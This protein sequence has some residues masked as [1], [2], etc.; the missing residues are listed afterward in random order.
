MKEIPQSVSESTRKRNPALY[1]TH[2][3]VPIAEAKPMERRLRQSSKPK[4]N[5]LENDFY[6]TIKS[7]RP[8]F[9]PIRI[10]AKRYLLGN[11]I[12]YKPDFTCSDY[13]KYIG[14]S[15]PSKETAWEVKGPH[16]FR[17]GYENLKV[18]ASTYPEIRF[19]LVWRDKQTGGWTQQEIL[20]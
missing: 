14:E 12:W 5:K 9:P 1:P 8:N 6:E 11:G 19:I 3:A 2:G 20:P 18:A 7:F 13:P 16:A 15:G 4:T 17:G 10:Q